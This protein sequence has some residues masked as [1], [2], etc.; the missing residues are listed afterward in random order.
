MI[1]GTAGHIDHGKTTLVRALTGVDTDRLKEE[2]ARG[3]SI[4][5]GFA[6]LPTEAGVLGFVDVP[7]HERFIHTMLAGA[8]S[9]DVALLVVAADDGV[10][11][12]TRE[13]L[14][15]LDLLG[16]TEGLVVLTKADLADD[17]RRAEVAAAIEALLADTGLAG[18]PVLA[19]SA[20]AGQGIPEL[21]AR[22]VEMAARRA[23]RNAEGRF[24][25]AVD[26]S[27]SL[28][29]AGTVV[30]GTVLSGVVRVDDRVMVSPAGLPARIRSIHAQNCPAAEGRAGERCA[31]NLAG[32]GITP[33][34]VGRGDVVLAPSLHAPTDRLDATLAVLGTEPRP[35][36]TWFPVR[37]HHGA[38]ETGARL[39]PLD[40]ETIAPGVTARVQIVLDH[41]IAAAVGDR[42]V[43]RDTSAQ[44][45]VGGGRLLDLRPPA[46]KRRGPGRLAQLDALALAQPDEALGALF[47][48]SPFFVEIDA[49]T[50][51]HALCESAADVLAGALDLVLLPPAQERVALAAARFETVRRDVVATLETFHGENPDLPGMGIEKL[52]L[53]LTPRLPK[54]AFIGALRMFA[55]AGAVVIDG[56]WLRLPEHEVRLT[57]GDKALWEAIAPLLDGEGRYRPPRVRDIAG[58]I[59]SEE[60]EV[61]R[62]MKLLARMGRVDEVAHDHFFRRSTVAHLVA[63]VG[64]LAAQGEKEAF[65]AAGFRDRIE[66]EELDAGRPQVGRKV[67]IQIL[68]F[69]DRH[70]VTLRRGDLRRINPHRLDLFGASPQ[71]VGEVRDRPAAE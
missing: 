60:P 56:A 69:L 2:K 15:L 66:R 45:T 6:Y 70:G 7:G 42:Y 53:A 55:T 21:K 22:L 10:M 68:E 9:I 33:D 41:P 19:V 17:T 37:F 20:T 65:T 51:D 29:G 34:R 30:T 36:G 23:A 26:R 46:R 18:A 3:I 16:I 38:T 32:D 62:L 31:L 54:V 12:Q 59:G 4:D 58:L 5:L 40:G 24:R 50:R 35:I 48:I 63:M 57:A 13:H 67:A 44:R 11:P 27:F 1:V 71:E 64:E 14:A 28:P 61:R 47:G 25:L 52:R 49:F 39:V 43:V 8:S